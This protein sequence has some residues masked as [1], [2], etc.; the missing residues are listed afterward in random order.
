MHL[1]VGSWLLVIKAF[2]AMMI[3]MDRV[4]GAR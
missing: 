4:I 3:S 1:V 2:L